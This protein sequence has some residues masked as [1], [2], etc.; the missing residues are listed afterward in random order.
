MIFDSLIFFL[1]ICKNVPIFIIDEEHII[2]IL[3]TGRYTMRID[4]YN[5][6]SQIYQTN[7]KTQ[8]ASKTSKN[9]TDKVEIS[10]TGK[11]FQT[12]KAALADI[13]DVREDKVAEIKAKLDAG[14]YDVSAEDLAAKL[15]EK[16]GTIY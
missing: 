3:I 9:R 15:A 16:F 12:V 14:T 7:N 11:D 5:Q 8:S 4:A 10:Q 13:P 2:I 1:S 6:V